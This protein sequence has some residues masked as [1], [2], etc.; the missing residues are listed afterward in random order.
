MTAMSAEA[1]RTDSLTSCFRSSL[2]DQLVDQRDPRWYIFGNYLL[3][4]RYRFLKFLRRAF[5]AWLVSQLT[6]LE[7]L[8][9]LFQPSFVAVASPLSALLQR[10][11]NCMIKSHLFV[12]QLQSLL[13]HLFWYPAAAK[14]VSDEHVSLQNPPCSS[15]TLTGFVARPEGLE[16]PTPRSE[17]WCSIR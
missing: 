4:P 11:R 9:E 16:P 3:D 10:L 14:V 7:P 15:L 8:L 5:D 1:S 12:K 13:N 6:R 2:S 17:A